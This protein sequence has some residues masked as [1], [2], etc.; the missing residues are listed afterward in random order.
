MVGDFVVDDVDDADDDFVEVREPVW[1]VVG[2]DERVADSD[3]LEV[4]E[5]VAV[6]V[7]VGDTLVVGLLEIVSVPVAVWVRVR[8]LE[9]VGEVVAV[10]VGV[11]DRLGDDVC[12]SD[13]VGSNDSDA[14]LDLRFVLEA[15]RFRVSV[16]DIV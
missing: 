9:S 8:L 15:R 10:R 4:A 7:D 5:V 1:E 16:F 11:N 6:G 3:W 12:D 13:F 2:L 14:V